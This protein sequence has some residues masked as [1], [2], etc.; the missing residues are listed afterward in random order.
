MFIDNNNVGFFFWR[1][2]TR[3]KVKLGDRTLHT[4]MG[5][6]IVPFLVLPVEAV[7]RK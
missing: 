5:L 1:A 4:E 3:E 2:G 6:K 7:R